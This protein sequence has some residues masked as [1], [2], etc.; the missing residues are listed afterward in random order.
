MS[1]LL[2]LEGT[3]TGGAPWVPLLGGVFELDIAVWLGQLC[4]LYHLD[5]LFSSHIPIYIP[6]IVELVIYCCLPIEASGYDIS[7]TSTISSV[8]TSVTV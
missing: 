5:L 4:L 3:F 1:C 8:I 6:S 7:F 2:F